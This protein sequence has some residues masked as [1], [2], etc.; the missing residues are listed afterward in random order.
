MKVHHARSGPRGFTL[1]ELLVAMSITLLIVTVL[2]SITS[3]A[4][5]TWNRSRSQLRAS[6]QAKAMIE[7]MSQDLESL[8]ARD[9]NNFEWL[10]AQSPSA[11]PGSSS[12]ASTNAVELVFLTAAT[13]R[14]QGA[15]DDPNA[16]GDVSGVGYLLEFKDPVT[17]AQSNGYSTFVLN[18]HLVNPGP[19]ADAPF[20]AFE[21]LLGVTD[22]NAAFAPAR[23]DMRNPDN[24]VCENV[25]QFTI[26]FQIEVLVTTGSAPNQVVTRYVIPVPVGAGGVSDFS[27][28]GTGI[29]W[30]GNPTLPVN[31]TTDALR[32]GRIAG[33][34][35]SLTVL[36]DAAV[37]RIRRN[38]LP[39]DA[40]DLAEF[41][42]ENSYN[43]SKFIPL[44]NQ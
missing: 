7:A 18:R 22:L 27:L 44:T 26:T 38:A 1:V 12:F 8:V 30:T 25:Y 28:K 16:K 14:Y 10:S 37:N 5:E 29:E 42:A 39:A 9:G 23:A 20:N 43:Y 13:D 2:V 3:I 15:L 19:T 35:L 6:R 36:T 34:D 40:D 4:M 31:V 33:I 21:S 32:A 17:G 11:L 41:L 24:F